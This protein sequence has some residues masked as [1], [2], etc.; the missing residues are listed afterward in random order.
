MDEEAAYRKAQITEAVIESIVSQEADGRHKIP[1]ERRPGAPAPLGEAAG[2]K[3][4]SA[5]RRSID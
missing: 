1:S 4:R 2:R 3:R 5:V